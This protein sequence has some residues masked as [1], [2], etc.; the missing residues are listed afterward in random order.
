[1]ELFLILL[2]VG[3]I[4]HFLAD[5]VLQND[6][7][8]KKGNKVGWFSPLFFHCLDHFV[9]F[10]VLFVLTGLF[11]DIVYYELFFMALVCS[12]LNSIIHFGVDRIK[13]HPKL[14][15]RWKF[16][17][18]MFFVSLGLDQMF[19]SITIILVI[20]LFFKWI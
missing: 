19:H 16:P 18:K 3:M 10:F 6:Y 2:C 4:A 1:M 11:V 12:L 15:G 5:F 17:Q 14:G 8:L 9:L 7:H 13:A 20:A